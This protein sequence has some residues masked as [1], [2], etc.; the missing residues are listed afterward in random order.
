MVIFVLVLQHEHRSS[1]LDDLS[2]YSAQASNHAEVIKTSD[3]Y[4]KP[5]QR[6]RMINIRFITFLP[7]ETREQTRNYKIEAT[8]VVHKKNNMI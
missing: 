4:W 8:H 2:F 3:L 7:L 6:S 5:L 1:R